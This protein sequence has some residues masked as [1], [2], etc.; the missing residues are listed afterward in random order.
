MFYLRV[1]HPEALPGILLIA[2]GAHLLILM[3]LHLDDTYFLVGYVKALL[4]IL[5]LFGVLWEGSYTLQMLASGV[6]SLAAAMLVWRDS[7]RTLRLY[8]IPDNAE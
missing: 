7:R 3:W 1:E 4:G 5:F 6:V 8:L 2:D